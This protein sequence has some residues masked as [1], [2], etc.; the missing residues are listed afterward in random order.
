MATSGQRREK[1]VFLDLFGFEWISGYT[2]GTLI[3]NVKLFFATCVFGS[4]W[5]FSW[6]FV[7][8]VQNPLWLRWDV[9]YS[10]GPLIFYEITQHWRWYN[11]VQQRHYISSEI[12][13]CRIGCVL[14]GTTSHTCGFKVTSYNA[15]L[16]F[17][18]FVDHF[19][20]QVTIMTTFCW[21]PIIIIWQS[22]PG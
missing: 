18:D 1:N 17:L 13:F 11:T 6:H 2:S 3:I 10:S 21:R 4:L 7:M 5:T 19:V 9:S 16:T 12:Q 15:L 8:Y 20:D 22:W 14:Y